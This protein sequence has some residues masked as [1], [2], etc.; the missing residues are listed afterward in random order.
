MAGA[1]VCGEYVVDGADVDG[2]VAARAVV[3][4]FLI[5]QP[6]ASSIQRGC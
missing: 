3:T 4:N 5:D 6:V 2:A 1:D